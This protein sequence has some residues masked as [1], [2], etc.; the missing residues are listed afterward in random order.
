MILAQL[1][2]ITNVVTLAWRPFLDPLDLQRWWWV[3]FFPLV[4]GISITYKAI[5]V[6]SMERYWRQTMKM[7]V[8]I[9]AA[10]VGLAFAIYLVVELLVPR[11]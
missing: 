8:Q 5:R 10:M 7:T 1:V 3:F 9:T 11:M 6:P 4:L 2:T